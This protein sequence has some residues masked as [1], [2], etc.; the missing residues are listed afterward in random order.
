MAEA[1]FLALCETL[2]S[3]EPKR[4]TE[5]WR[6][7]YK[8]VETR[9][10]GKADVDDLIHMVFRRINFTAAKMSVGIHQSVFGKLNYLFLGWFGGT[11][12]L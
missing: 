1:A 6:V 3:C 7:L 8:T 5:L 4:G 9:F 10:V 12:A 2:L 11:I